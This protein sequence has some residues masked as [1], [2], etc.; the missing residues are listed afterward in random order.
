[1]GQNIEIGGRNI[2]FNNIE[3]YLAALKERSRA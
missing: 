2:K 1:M 3:L